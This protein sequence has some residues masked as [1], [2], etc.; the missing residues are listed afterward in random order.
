[1]KFDS[2]Q[3]VWLWLFSRVLAAPYHVLTREF[4][5]FFQRTWVMCHPCEGE[6]LKREKMAL[7][8][9]QASILSVDPDPSHLVS[10]ALGT[11]GFFPAITGPLYLSQQND[12]K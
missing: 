3:L 8:L 12:Q 11:S 6:I 1:L 7:F 2:P 10:Q 9:F 5:A 4:S